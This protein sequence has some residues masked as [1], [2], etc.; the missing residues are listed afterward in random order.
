MKDEL[1]EAVTRAGNDP[2]L[3]AILAE[4]CET[5]DMGFAAIACVTRDRWIACQVED[6][7]AFGLDPGSELDIKTTICD[8]IRDFGDAIVIDDVVSDDRWRNHHTP[9]FYG[10]KSYASFPL[11]LDGG[12]FFGTLCALGDEP[13]AISADK[14]IASFKEWAQKVAAILSE[15]F[16][17]EGLRIKALADNPRLLHSVDMQASRSSPDPSPSRP[18]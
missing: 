4:V 9:V 15:R 12:T 16:V 18:S 17:S 13:R 2:R 10:F 3:Q 5:A 14:M 11:Y 6:K 7:V 1:A 8:E